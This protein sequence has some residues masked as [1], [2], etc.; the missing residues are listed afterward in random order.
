[1]S[2]EDRERWD[3]RHAAGSHS[4]VPT[5]LWLDELGALIPAQ[6]RALDVATGSGRIGLW[7]AA[8]GLEVTAVDISAVGLARCQVTASRLGLRMHMRHV[9]LEEEPLPRG[10]W[11]VVTCFH[12]L[13]RALFPVLRDALAPGGLLICEIAT[14]RN[15]ERHARP[16]ARFLL[17][18]GELAELVA[19]LDIVHG[20]EGWFD[21]RAL[22]RV[23]A[24]R[25][26]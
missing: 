25:A 9:D 14:R 15:L 6:G 2:D 10:P 8:R 1:M 13:Q 12:Y 3:R 18:E 22:A 23:V 19:P 24:R 26:S 16:S 11:Q 21:D 20:E 7:L 17:E 4:E 5:G